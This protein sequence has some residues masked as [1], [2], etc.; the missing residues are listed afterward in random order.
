MSSGCHYRFYPFNKGRSHAFDFGKDWL[1]KYPTTWCV[2]PFACGES[3][4]KIWVW[5]FLPLLVLNL[6]E[7]GWKFLPF[8]SQPWHWENI[9]WN[10]E[11][12]CSVFQNSKSAHSDKK[13]SSENQTNNKVLE[14][15][16]DQS[17]IS[18]SP[19]SQ[20]TFHLPI[21]WMVQSPLMGVSGPFQDKI[22]HCT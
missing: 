2:N 11:G 7:A 1:W 20:P 16:K 22:W 3:L 5:Y 12:K 13:H 18:S 4:Q 15:R 14:T 6:S 19:S 10:G 21:T 17:Q 9:T 8:R